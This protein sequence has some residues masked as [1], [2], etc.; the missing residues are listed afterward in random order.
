[1]ASTE[2]GWGGRRSPRKLANLNKLGAVSTFAGEETAPKLC[3][4]GN[5]A[6]RAARR[7]SVDDSDG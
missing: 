4:A 6:R 2:F 7:Y 3:R 1:M 5:G